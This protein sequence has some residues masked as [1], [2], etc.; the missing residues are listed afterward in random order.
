MKSPHYSLTV[1][2]LFIFFS[3]KINLFIYLILLIFFHFVSGTE[4]HGAPACLQKKPIIVGRLVLF[5]TFFSLLFLLY[6]FLLLCTA[7][8]FSSF[9]LFCFFTSV[10]PPTHV[11][12]C[13]ANYYY[14]FWLSHVNVLDGFWIVLIVYVSYHTFTLVSK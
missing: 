14:T 6:F 2:N 4:L 5:S 8:L 7:F 13:F 1:T 9:D 12:S 11:T 3:K 10:S